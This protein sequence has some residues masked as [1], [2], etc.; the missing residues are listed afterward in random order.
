MTD[1]QLANSMDSNNCLCSEKEQAD[2]NI[3]TSR[4]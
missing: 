3:Q 4:M 1:Q 2:T